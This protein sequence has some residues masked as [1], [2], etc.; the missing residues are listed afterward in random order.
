[1]YVVAIFALAL[2]SPLPFVSPFVYDVQ[3]VE[4]QSSNFDIITNNADQQSQSTAP[5]ELNTFTLTSSTDNT[6]PSYAKA[7]DTITVTFTTDDILHYNA[8]ATINDKNASV[9]IFNNVLT[10]S[11]TVLE[12][13]PDGYI[14]FEINV[15][16][17]LDKRSVSDADINGDVVFVDKHVPVIKING[18]PLV[19]VEQNGAYTELGASV[20]DTDPA[21]PDDA[22]S[23]SDNSSNIPL[24]TIG[25]YTIVY[26]AVNDGAGNEPFSKTR[27]VSVESSTITANVSYVDTET[28][29][30]R[31]NTAAPA[32]YSGPVD[33][34]SAVQVDGE[35][36]IS[37]IVPAQIS[38]ITTFDN[39]IPGLD[40]LAYG[41]KFG[42]SVAH[43]GDLNQD[44]YE[45]V[46]VGIP[47]HTSFSDR[48]GAVA[49]LHLGENA[50]SV[51]DVFVHDGD[52][53]NMPPLRQR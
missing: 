4:A 2:L 30:L 24:D 13:D 7:G 17:D 3:N 11:I 9:S 16:S 33:L 22:N 52:S 23:L 31:F 14:N 43:M 12:T 21:Y 6:N 15:S 44:G 26:T 34:T 45:D 47:Q 53:P 25:T 19:Y 50:Q 42:E 18:P 32:F 46:V 8:T 40:F 28:I 49:I 39:S 51:L 10:A 37:A 48:G 5:Q 41:S 1:M 20:F 38:S 27:I 36:V 35:N 29:W